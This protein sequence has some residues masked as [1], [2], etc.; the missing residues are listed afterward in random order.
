MPNTFLDTVQNTN[1]TNA[2]P[3]ALVNRTT[4]EINWQMLAS[5]L[6]S[7]IFQFIMQN[8]DNETIKEFGINLA[9]NLAKNFSITK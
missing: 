8:Q 9:T 1:L 4:K 6:D 2:N 3:N 5:Y 7:E